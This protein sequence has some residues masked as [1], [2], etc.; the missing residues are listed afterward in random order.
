[1]CK[2]LT[3]YF[4]RNNDFL[5]TYFGKTQN[6]NVLNG[7]IDTT[8]EQRRKVNEFVYS[9]KELPQ[10]GIEV[11]FKKLCQEYLDYVKT[12][13]E[14]PSHKEGATLYNWLKKTLPN[15]LSY[16]DNRKLYFTKLIE[17]LET[18]GFYIG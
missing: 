11:R 17:E 14:L 18:Y 4:P 16:D 7:N 8:E 12:N 9:N 15:Y 6:Y 10:N 2:S 3:N 13:Y 1:M 5:V